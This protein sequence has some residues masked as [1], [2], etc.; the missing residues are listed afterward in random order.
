[1]DSAH[2][3]IIQHPGGYGAQGRK[4]DIGVYWKTRGFQIAKYLSSHVAPEVADDDS[5]IVVGDDHDDHNS[6]T[7]VDYT[8]EFYIGCDRSVLTVRIR[9]EELRESYEHSVDTHMVNRY[10]GLVHEGVT[11]EEPE[12]EIEL[13][14]QEIADIK[15]KEFPYSGKAKARV[16]ELQ[17]KLKSISKGQRRVYLEH[18]RYLSARVDHIREHIIGLPPHFKPDYEYILRAYETELRKRSPLGGDDGASSS[19]N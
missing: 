3:H 2:S 1:M 7:I 17:E 14:I 10:L 18:R 15:K 8:K 9:D 4:F 6:M 5:S 13:A 12:T 19:G 16:S 11:R